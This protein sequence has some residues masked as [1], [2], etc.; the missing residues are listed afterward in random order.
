MTVHFDKY[1][2][3]KNT[4]LSANGE[5]AVNDIF[6]DM[7]A[8]LSLAYISDL[9]C[10][11][12]QVFKKLKKMNLD[13]YSNRQLEDFSN[14]VFGISLWALKRSLEKGMIEWK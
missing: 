2:V 8:E 7:Q 5:T 13:K 1:N 11:K 14:Y 10:H 6:L 9:V 12:R 3:I 4:K